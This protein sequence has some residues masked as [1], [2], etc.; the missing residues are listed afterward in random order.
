MTHHRLLLTLLV[1]S[2]FI[3]SEL[4]AGPDSKLVR[5]EAIDHVWAG[6]YVRFDMLHRDD[7]SFIGYYDA[8]RQLT[9]AHRKGG[10]PWVYYKLD[11]YYGW[12]SHNYI[13][14][15]LDGEG[16]LHVLANMHNHALEYFRTTRSFD[17]RTLER[18]RVMANPAVEMGMTYP[19]FLRDKDGQLLVKYRDGSSGN[20]VEI[21][22]RYDA[23][24]RTW[25]PLHEQPLIDGE[26]LMNAYVAGPQLGPDGLFHMI[27][28]WRD[29]PDAATNH[30]LSYARSPDLLSWESASGVPVGLPITIATGDIID[31]IPARSGLINGGARLGFDSQQRPIVAYHKYDENGWTQI[32]LARAIDGIWTSQKITTWDGFRWDFGGTGSLG[33]FEVRMN[34][35]RAANDGTLEVDVKRQGRSLRL[36]VDEESLILQG[37]EPLEA[38]PAILNRYASSTGV[39]LDGGESE[40]HER[41]FRTLST[42]V[43]DRRYVLSWEAQAPYR[44]QAREAI[45][46]A[47]TL[48][49]HTFETSSSMKI[50][51]P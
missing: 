11:S 20:G 21:Y 7:H 19:N 35:I 31:P 9:I 17:I 49:L 28:V 39:I 12:D 32:Y 15:E 1:S 14:M 23:A 30:D 5:T 33:V 13:E 41:I 10:S 29:T 50:K 43:S 51:G 4:Y 45:E 44:G 24:T 18:V 36:I 37:E 6:N 38:Y 48:R 8:N 25:T 27:W 34:G 22:N 26:G 16:I 46:P 47:A 40:G 3:F 2:L 42:S